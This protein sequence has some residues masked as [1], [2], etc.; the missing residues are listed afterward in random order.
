[1]SSLKGAATT[2]KGRNKNMDTKEAVTFSRVRA[3]SGVAGL[4]SVDS[5]INV[6]VEGKFDSVEEARLLIQAAPDLL[7]AAQAYMASWE[8][9]PVTEKEKAREMLRAAI[10]RATGGK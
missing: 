3:I 1:L 9:S 8:D 10:L 6:T 7:A 5:R 2:N 4:T